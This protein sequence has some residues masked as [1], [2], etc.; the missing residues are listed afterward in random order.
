MGDVV[1]SCPQCGTDLED[2]GSGFWCPECEH[3]WTPA[4]ADMWNDY[5]EESL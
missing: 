1:W 2:D 3:L 4:G 5:I